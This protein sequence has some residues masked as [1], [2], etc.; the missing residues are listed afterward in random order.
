MSILGGVAALAA[1]IAIGDR[2]FGE[3]LVLALGSRITQ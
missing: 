1:I 2:F 3:W